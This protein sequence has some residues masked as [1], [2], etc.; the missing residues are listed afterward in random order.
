[1]ML[2]IS[3]SRFFKS[4][5]L[6]SGPPFAVISAN[7]SLI[8]CAASRASY[9]IFKISRSCSGVRVPAFIGL[10]LASRATSAAALILVCLYAL[11]LPVPSMRPLS[12]SSASAFGNRA[13]ILANL[14][15]RSA[16]S[17]SGWGTAEFVIESGRIKPPVSLDA[18]TCSCDSPL[19]PSLDQLRH[20]GLWSPNH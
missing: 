8:T 16:G 10:P 14:A 3:S 4:L 2:A 15:N 6:I 7:R 12:L 18:R 1:M 13:T 9:A 5:S 11:L 19:V 20:K 17:N